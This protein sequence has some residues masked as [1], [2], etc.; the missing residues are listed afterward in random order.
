[1]MLSNLLECGKWF[2]CRVSL[3][4]PPVERCCLASNCWTKLPKH[5][6]CDPHFLEFVFTVCLII[7]FVYEK[8]RTEC[9]HVSVNSGKCLHIISIFVINCQHQS[10]YALVINQMTR[11]VFQKLTFAIMI[12]HRRQPG[13]IKLHKSVFLG[14]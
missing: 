7:F 10:L 9:V 8:S 6:I 11:R 2:S 5:D 12:L 14:S 3:V 13:F 4:H 1:M